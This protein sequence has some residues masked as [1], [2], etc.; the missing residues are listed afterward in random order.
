MTF[1]QGVA[2]LVSFIGGLGMFLFGMNL[3]GEGL[4][5]AAGNRLSTII[6]KMTDR[7]GKG[8]LAGMLVTAIIQ[9][10]S[11]T[12]VMVVGFVNA[13]IMKLTQA[14]GVIIGAN[15]GTTV[16]AQLLSL[17]DI[18][19]NAWYLAMLKPANFAPILIGIGVV[20]VSFSKNKTYNYIGNI[21]SGFAMIFIG[22]STMEGAAA[23]LS[24]LPQ[25]QHLFQTL[26]NPILG[27]LTGMAVTAIIQSSSASI[28]ILQAATS[29]GSITFAAAAPIVLGQNIGTCVTAL[30]SAVGANKNAKRAAIVHLFYNIIGVAVFMIALYAV[31]GL[32][33]FW[34]DV[35]GKS[36]VAN[37]HLVFNLLEVLMWLP[38]HKFLVTIANHLIP[39]EKKAEEDEEE[40]VLDSRFLQNPSMAVEQ[41]RKATIQMALLAKENYSL[42]RHAIVEHEYSAEELLRSNEKKIDAYESNIWRYLMS[43]V[44]EDLNT[45][46]S[47]TTSNLFHVLIDLERIGDRCQ[48]VF[49]IAKD[50]QADG[51]VLSDRA[52]KGLCAMVDAVGE[53]LN[54][55]IACYEKMDTHI[56]H[57]ITTYEKVV[58]EIQQYLRMGHLSRMARQE[59]GFDAAIVYL[60]MASNL[61][62]ISDH[63]ANIATSVEQ[64]MSDKPDFDPHK[65]PKAFQKE[66][67]KEY[68]ELYRKFE[69]KYRV[70]IA[71]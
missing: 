55:A 33:P 11:A 67:P 7:L 56:S 68:A 26:T 35:V 1:T 16:T 5:R 47:K 63:C 6:E 64:L 44:N 65:D 9:S 3:M 60:D 19:G 31:K 10:S 18:S 71:D 38:F 4:E 29:T 48:N 69:E 43:I 52:H 21:L 45:A 27:V 54:L 51:I 66:N 40:S 59:C 62:R 25:F 32:L 28:G 30:L 39:D 49:N 46:D 24:D 20:L 34:N 14:V 13:G 15:V 61:E 41:A 58:D 22:M 17:S 37:F 42:C 50:M 2:M 70:K 8:I 36:G 12:T 23:P 57:E 53:M